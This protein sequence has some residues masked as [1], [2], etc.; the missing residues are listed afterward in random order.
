MRFGQTKAVPWMI[1]LSW[2]LKQMG[3]VRGAWRARRWEYT[4]LGPGW[5]KVAGLDGP[6][7]M[8]GWGAS[9]CGG[10]RIGRW[11]GGMTPASWFIRSFGTTDP[12]C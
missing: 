3:Q 12:P 5:G 1:S 2:I 11:A 4:E 9:R 6:P 10:G 8:N 7:R